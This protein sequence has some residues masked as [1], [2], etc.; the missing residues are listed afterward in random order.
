MNSQNSEVLIFTG[1][2]GAGKDSVESAFRSEN[3]EV[4][5]IVRHITRP[6]NAAELD[7]IDY[8]FVTTD[9][10]HRMISLDKFIEYAR[11]PD[12]YSGTSYRSLEIALSKTN[13]ASLTANVE[14]A[15]T[16]VEK[17]ERL[18]Y[19][20]RSFFISPVSMDSFTNSPEQ[21]LDTLKRRMENRGRPDDRIVNKL[22]KAAI[23]R[24]IYL[25]QPHLFQYIPNVNDRLGTAVSMVSASLNLSR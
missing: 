23:Y 14:D 22:G 3:A 25:K 20:V 12:V 15:T 21:Y 6:V 18:G 5:K 9:E 7:G 16:L 4:S 1:P 13:Y 11:Y 10:F 17:I 19:K 8:H 24:E 2:H